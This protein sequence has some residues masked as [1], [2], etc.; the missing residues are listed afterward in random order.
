MTTTDRDDALAVFLVHHEDGDMYVAA[1]DYAEAE[2]KWNQYQT[3]LCGI[4]ES[5]APPKM[6][7]K[8]CDSEEFI[9]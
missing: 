1:K 7:S 8:L 4:G 9:P 2:A 5:F 6:I 3:D